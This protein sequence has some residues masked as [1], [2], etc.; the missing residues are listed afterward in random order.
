M[1]QTPRGE[2]FDEY[3]PTLSDKEIS[4]AHDNAKI[5]VS[6]NGKLCLLPDS[7]TFFAVKLSLYDGSLLTLL[8]DRIST[9]ALSSSVQNAIKGHWKARAGI[10]E[11]G[12]SA[13]NELLVKNA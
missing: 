1:T 6:L 3:K 13:T 4:E 2:A 9:L 7:E 10:E 12:V 8:L 5:V 11:P